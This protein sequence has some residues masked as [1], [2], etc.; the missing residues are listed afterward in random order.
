MSSRAGKTRSIVSKKRKSAQIKVCN[1][2]WESIKSDIEN[3]YIQRGMQ[4]EE[5]MAAI[6]S[7]HDFSARYVTIQV[8]D[9]NTDVI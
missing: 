8:F 1:Q 5:T 3:L 6:K 7:A 2:I 9:Y 4:L